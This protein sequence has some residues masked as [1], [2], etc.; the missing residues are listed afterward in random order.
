MI[1]ALLVVGLAFFNPQ[2]PTDSLG[3]ETIDGKLFI[4]HKV[5]EKETLY[6]ISRRYGV[7]LNDVLQF[8]PD[9]DAGLE[10]GQILKIPYSG[11]PAG[12]STRQTQGG[13]IHKVAEK[14][15]L[16]S[17]SRMYGITVDEIRLW[18]NLTSSS[19]S[20]GQELII[21]STD[22]AST[23]QPG[24]QPDKPA[25][26]M[27]KGVH[28]VKPGETLFAIAQQYDVRVDELR[29]WNSL[30]GNDLK[31]G[32]L[33][34]VAPPARGTTA[35]PPEA[36]AVPSVAPVAATGP[37][38]EAP[39]EKPA[40]QPQ[41]QT[42]TISTIPGGSDEIVQSGLAELIEGTEG[43]RKYLALHRTA[44]V[45][46]I[47]K[48]RNEMNNR[49]VFVR[50]MG[51]LPDTALTDKLVIKVSKSAYDRLGAIDPRF[52]VEITYYK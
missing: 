19:L 5:E 31:A 39:L 15:T 16:F 17:I 47:L 49:E 27:Q 45:G 22:T 52:R 38:V 25:M 46:T 10:I 9:A 11:R 42:V 14:E 1:Q 30:E 48:V 2:V 12:P 50:V 41:P 4:L 33:L 13:G 21:R 8:N 24:Q 43:N 29:R 44:P 6:G 3:T 20:I 37:A 23:S 7:Y 36:V 28:E 35:T 18:N 34:F 32:Q 40:T 51:K 26:K